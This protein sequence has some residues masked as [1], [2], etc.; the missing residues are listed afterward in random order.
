[1]EAQI[2]GFAAAQADVGAA[3]LEL[4]EV[5]DVYASHQAHR[6]SG[7]EAELHEP[8][9]KGALSADLRQLGNLAGE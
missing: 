5:S 7:Q 4:D 2:A 3:N 9:A 1:V 6:R 8:P